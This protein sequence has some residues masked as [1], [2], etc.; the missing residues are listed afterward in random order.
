[1]LPS[2]G[3][4]DVVFMTTG[5]LVPGLRVT[6]EDNPE[7]ARLKGSLKILDVLAAAVGDRQRLPAQPLPIAL[8]DVTV[9]IDAETAAWARDEARASGLP[10]N[11]ARA[12]FT[13]IITYVLTER[14]I[15][16]ISRGWL[17][18][19]DREAWEDLR[20]DLLRELADDDKFTPPRSTN[21]GRY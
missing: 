12:V 5:D 11:E 18:R 10:H 15:G 4:S 21:S 13:E 1:V 9:R 19:S 8:A 17:S 16:R 6:A 7:A 2:L 20:S 3:E 14:A